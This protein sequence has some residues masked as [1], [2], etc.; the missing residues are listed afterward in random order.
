MQPTTLHMALKG[1]CLNSLERSY[2]SLHIQSGQ[3]RVDCVAKHIYSK[4]VQSCSGRLVA[5][6]LKLYYLVTNS[7]T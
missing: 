7:N 5:Q 2:V 4:V 6:T 1:C 3:V